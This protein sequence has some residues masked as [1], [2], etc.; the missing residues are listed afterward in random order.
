V[1]K[2]STGGFC[3]SVVRSMSGGR[4]ELEFRC[5]AAQPSPVRRSDEGRR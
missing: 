2:F 4:H 1:K 3:V 5:G